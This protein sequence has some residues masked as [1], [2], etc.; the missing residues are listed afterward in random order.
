[1]RLRGHDCRYGIDDV[2]DCI[3]NREP[4]QRHRKASHSQPRAEHDRGA[5]HVQDVTDIVATAS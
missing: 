4:R 2:G 1:V 5:F 3:G